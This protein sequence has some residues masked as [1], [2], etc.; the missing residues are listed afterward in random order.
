MFSTI[1][2]GQIPSMQ[3]V[4]PMFEHCTCIKHLCANFRNKGHRGVLLKDL[5]WQATSSYTKAEFHVVMDE[6][7]KNSED[8]CAYLSKVDPNTWFK[9]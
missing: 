5:L 1:V 4:C 6:I 9:G 8:A 2:Q 3:Q 7:K